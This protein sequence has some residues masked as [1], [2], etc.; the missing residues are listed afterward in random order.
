MSGFIKGRDLMDEIWKSKLTYC[1]IIDPA[2]TIPDTFVE[3]LA[4]ID[5]SEVQTV[6]VVTPFEPL[7]EAKFPTFVVYRVENGSLRET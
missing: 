2:F 7:I 3:S 1:E 6:C 5:K 4:D